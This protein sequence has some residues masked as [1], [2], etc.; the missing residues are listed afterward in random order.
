VNK[1][2]FLRRPTIYCSP[3]KLPGQY[4]SPLRRTRPSHLSP[5]RPEYKHFPFFTCPPF[6]LEDDTLFRTREMLCRFSCKKEDEAPPPDRRATQT[7]PSRLVSTPTFGVCFSPPSR[8]RHSSPRLHKAQP[9]SSHAI[10]N[11][12]VFFSCV[13]FFLSPIPRLRSLFSAVPPCESLTDSKQFLPLK[14]A[15]WLPILLPSPINLQ[16][17]QCLSTSP[18]FLP[19]GSQ[20]S[21]PALPRET[22]LPCRLFLISNVNSSFFL[23]V[24]QI[25][26]VIA[27]S[28]IAIDSVLFSPKRCRPLPL[29]F[30]NTPCRAFLFLSDSPSIGI[31]ALSFP[32]KRILYYFFAAQH[33]VQASRFFLLGPAHV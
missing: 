2:L 33:R 6:A 10:S 26:I 17:M 19:G 12:L 13:L 27:S 14:A 31:S 20:E 32:R 30:R 3:L 22:A 23:P 21:T 25:E 1:L 8:W 9:F 7:F 24:R 28:L 5:S 16:P 15:R 11:K 29:S 4:V 18:S